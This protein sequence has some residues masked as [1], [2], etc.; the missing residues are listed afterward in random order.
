MIITLANGKEIVIK[1]VVKDPK[2]EA[3]QWLRAYKENTKKSPGRTQASTTP[4][5]P[6]EGSLCNGKE[7][8]T[9]R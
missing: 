4:I 6:Q 7:N 9:T 5:S 1:D 3:I 2:A 8:S